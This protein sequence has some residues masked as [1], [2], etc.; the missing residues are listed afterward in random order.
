MD[1]LLSV[2]VSDYRYYGPAIG[3]ASGLSSDL[4][5]WFDA[6]KQSEKERGIPLHGII[7]EV[8]FFLFIIIITCKSALQD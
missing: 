6:V 7:V 8:L 4:Q 5:T 1:I 3:L 2:H